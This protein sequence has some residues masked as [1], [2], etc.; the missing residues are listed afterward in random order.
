MIV[1]G[2]GGA[3]TRANP[4]TPFPCPISPNADGVGATREQ[5]P[6]STA[7]VKKF[8]IRSLARSIR[9][10]SIWPHSEGMSVQESTWCRYRHAHHEFLSLSANL[11]TSYLEQAIKSNQN[12]HSFQYADQSL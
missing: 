6:G 12:S 9:S 3:E 8:Q 4:R 10:L 5:G 7:T 1:V 11:V 2:G